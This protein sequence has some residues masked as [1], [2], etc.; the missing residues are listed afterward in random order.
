M[1]ALTPESVGIALAAVATAICSAT[2]TPI[3]RRVA[4][5]YGLIDRPNE[6]SSHS[7]PTPRGG[8]IAIVLSVSL[9]LAVLVKLVDLPT[10]MFAALAG[11]GAAVAII[12]F[13]DDCRP[14]A[15]WLRLLVHIA[16]ALWALAWLGGVPPFA[17]GAH[18]LVLKWVA[19][20]FGVLGI[21]WAINLFNF[22]DGIDAIAASEGAFVT[23]AATFL[24]VLCG[25][26]SDIS[27]A[28]LMIAAACMGFLLWN[29][30]PARIFMGDVGSGYIGYAVAVL[31]LAAT[32][33]KPWGV[34]VWLTLGG[35][36]FVDAT[37]TLIRRLIRGERVYE[38]HRSHAYQ[39]LTRRWGSHLR[40]SLTVL[41]LNVLWLLPCATYAALHP[42]YA[43]SATTVALGPLVVV[44]LLAGSGRREAP[45]RN[46]Q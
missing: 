26:T 34:W 28:S 32:R 37:V 2:L 36:F 21:V 1:I 22:M 38:A 15:A 17:V 6:R 14:R 3:A 10:G 8:G 23:G 29:W 4:I 24:M 20:P 40:V 9:S 42:A 43:L 46:G 45:Q 7:A 35:V 27:A 33:E 11:G 25:I 19:Y 44:A 30:P 18:T 12:G 13:L 16:A 5:G 31:A 39:W 41:I